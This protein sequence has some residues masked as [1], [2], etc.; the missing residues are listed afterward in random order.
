MLRGEL[1]DR[2]DGSG[3]SFYMRVLFPG[4]I[5]VSLLLDL[6]AGSS[7][8]WFV[9]GEAVVLLV[10]LAVVAQAFGIGALFESRAEL[11]DEAVGS[12]ESARDLIRDLD[13]EEP[14]DGG[15]G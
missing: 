8:P 3:W 14:R 1:P 5:I 10:M 11:M 15:S 4:V 12:D 6:F 2:V 13:G 9:A 7:W